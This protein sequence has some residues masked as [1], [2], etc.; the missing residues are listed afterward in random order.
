M[1]DNIVKRLLDAGAQVTEM[2]Q[3][4]ADQ[5]VKDLQRL[6]GLR[7]QEAE[8]AVNELMARGRSTTESVV[9]NVQR[10]VASQIGRVVERMD[11][12]EALLS[13]VA[14]RVGVSASTK[15]S[16]TKKSTAKKAPAKKSTAKKAPA[17]KAAA[18]KAPAKKATA[19]KSTAKK[20]TAKKSTARKSTARKSTAKKATATTSTAD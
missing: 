18:K 2:S 3:T 13:D 10:E 15:K 17:K 5:L 11:R 7:R 4:R 16:T 12:I 9:A 14:T 1:A 20:S 19:K 8:R 6:G